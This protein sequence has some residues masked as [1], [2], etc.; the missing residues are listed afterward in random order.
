MSFVQESTV[1]TICGV[2][3]MKK[4][5]GSNRSEQDLLKLHDS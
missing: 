3:R 4:R 1:L 2:P 5:M